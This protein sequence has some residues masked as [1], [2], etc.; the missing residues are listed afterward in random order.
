MKVF[1]GLIALI[2]F[3]NLLFSQPLAVRGFEWRVIET[4]HYDVVYVE[5]LEAEA[6]YVA[7]SLEFLLAMHSDALGTIRNYR[8]SVVLYPNT[9]TVNGYVRFIPRMSAYYTTPMGDW[10]G[11]WLSIL[12][13]HEARHKIQFDA[14]DRYTGRFLSRLAGEIGLLAP[15]VSGPG[16]FY[17]GDAV[18]AETV[19]T[20][21]GRGRDPSFSAPLKALLLD[22]K[23]FTYNKMLMGSEKDR[24]PN[25]YAFGYLMFAFIRDVYD[26]RAAQTF[27]TALAQYPFPVIGPAIAIR[28]ATG[29]PA[30]EIYS[31]M[32]EYY[33]TFWAEQI[34]SMAFTETRRVFDPDSRFFTWYSRI[35]A[36]DDG[37][38]V[39]AV[40]DA[41]GRRIVRVED[42][43]E[44]VLTRSAPLN[45]LS[46]G[47][48][49][50]VW[51][52]A[53]SDVKF[54]SSR[55]RIA[56]LDLESGRKSTIDGD[57]RYVYP[58]VSPDGRRIA[59]LEWDGSVYTGRF[60]ILDALSGAVVD[61]VAIPRGE[62]WFDFSWNSE[63]TE[64]V[65]VASNADGKAIIGISPE[66][67]AR[68]TYIP[69]GTE[70]IRQIHHA[71]D[72]ILY[73]SNYSG[74]DAIY[75]VTPS[76]E[77]YSV[78]SR[79]IGL[80]SP[81]V[82]SRGSEVAFIEY[83]DSLGSIVAAVPAHPD[84]WVAI[85]DVTVIREEFFL[86]AAAGEIGAGMYVPENVPTVEYESRSYSF[87]R[88]GNRLHSW[89]VLP[90]ELDPNPSARGFVMIDS[91]AGTVSQEIGLTYGSVT[92]S[93]GL[94]YTLYHRV[95]RPDLFLRGE[96]VFDGLGESPMNTSR[97]TFGVEYP[98]GARVFGNVSW[99]LAPSTAIGAAAR[100]AADGTHLGTD[101]SIRHRLSGSFSHGRWS[102]GA[103]AAY[104]YRP[105]AQDFSD[106]LGVRATGVS[107]GL[108]E[109]DA[110]RAGV[111]YDRVGGP[112][113]AVVSGPRGYGPIATTEMI[114]GR[115][116]YTVPLGYPD[117]AFGPIV[118]VN[119]V[120]AT[121]FYDHGVALDAGVTYRSLGAELRIHFQPLQ[122]PVDLDIAVRASWLVDAQRMQYEIIAIGFPIPVN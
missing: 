15:F 8:Y 17:E 42:E 4:E 63:A 27:F 71:D 106:S 9:M 118:Y 5:T 119:R 122:L 20:E 72:A 120:S 79:P 68:R 61:A 82:A 40:S 57:G 31:E 34:A 33:G 81:V 108:L 51:D 116:Q 23:P 86:P 91:I 13:V 66:A 74:I 7:N 6:Q 100:F 52:E 93:L 107:P 99:L 36:L 112:F 69:F 80:H 37:T 88:S 58:A 89:G 64:I 28:R 38:L 48:G 67:H 19:L 54:D 96:T 105:F 3:P 87:A 102:V 55:T 109:R 35:A 114:S 97:L 90:V 50:V 56:V 22:G 78:V 117:L 115:A 104:E 77:R 1:L 94:D 49:L 121:G 113:S 59:A 24:I 30:G 39:V 12:S 83:A 26:E 32:A 29:K 84:A 10:V 21:T 44:T 98:I 43:G 11:D 16:W 2:L 76:G 25:I 70:N 95:F 101:V 92:R 41:A 47:G 75:S 46:A 14:L 18:M 111:S 60:V 45:S 53:V 103:A 62:F 65:F 85:D 110:F 73:V